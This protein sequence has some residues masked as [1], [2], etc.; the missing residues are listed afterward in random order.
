M[1]CRREWGVNGE[2]SGKDGGT[3]AAGKVMVAACRVNIN[4]IEDMAEATKHGGR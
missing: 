2:S 4:M 3:Q 1:A